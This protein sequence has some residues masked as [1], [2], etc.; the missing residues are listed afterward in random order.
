MR[1][2]RLLPARSD[3]DPMQ[4]PHVLSVT[5][6][7][8]YQRDT[9]RLRYR[10]VGEK[11]GGMYPV[12]LRGRYQDVFAAPGEREAHLARIREFMELP[13]ISHSVGEVYAFNRKQGN[14]ERLDRK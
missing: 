6:V 1:G 9:A 3:I 12:P 5:F 8:D 4:I 7:C 2:D 14:G 10:L 13:A 11:L